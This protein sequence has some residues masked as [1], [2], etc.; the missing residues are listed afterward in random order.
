MRDI[1]AEVKK[2]CT[3][4]H[5]LKVATEAR[6]EALQAFLNQEQALGDML[7]EGHFTYQGGVLY[8]RKRSKKDTKHDDKTWLVSYN[9]SK[10]IL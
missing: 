8:I 10:P 3:N 9:E 1:K 2:F 7:G 4:L 5:V 6:E